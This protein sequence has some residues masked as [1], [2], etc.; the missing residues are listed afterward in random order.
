MKL[1]ES[2]KDY[3]RKFH[4]LSSDQRV[5]FLK[6]AY[7]EAL[8]KTDA[9]RGEFT[10]IALSP[11]TMTAP[12]SREEKEELLESASKLNFLM[13]RFYMERDPAYEGHIIELSLLRFE[14]LLL[15]GD[16][17]LSQDPQL[18]AE[19]FTARGKPELVRPAL[20]RLGEEVITTI[21]AD[22]LLNH[23]V[24]EQHVGDKT[25]VYKFR[26]RLH[27]LRTCEDYSKEQAARTLLSEG[28]DLRACDFNRWFATE[29]D[30]NIKIGNKHYVESRKEAAWLDLFIKKQTQ[31]DLTISIVSEQ[32]ALT[33]VEEEEKEDT[34]SSVKCSKESIIQLNEKI[35]RVIEGQGSNQ[36]TSWLRELA[37][38][39]SDHS[40]LRLDSANAVEASMWHFLWEGNFIKL[41]KQLKGDN[42][43]GETRNGLL[44]NKWALTHPE[45]Q[46]TLDPI[47]A[48]NSFA[49]ILAGDILVGDL[50]SAIQNFNDPLLQRYKNDAKISAAITLAWK[51]LHHPGQSDKK[52]NYK[53]PKNYLFSVA[54]SFHTYLTRAPHVVPYLTLLKASDV[55]ELGKQ[56]KNILR[57]I[58]DF[59]TIE[60][61][62]TQLGVANQIEA[63]FLKIFD[64]VYDR[65]TRHMSIT[66][67]AA[68]IITTIQDPIFKKYVEE[69]R[70]GERL[71]A[72]TRRTLTGKNRYA[73]DM[74]ALEGCKV[75]LTMYQSPVLRPYLE[76]KL[77]LSKLLHGMID[78][79]IAPDDPLLTAPYSLNGTSE[80]SLF[81]EESIEAYMI[82]DQLRAHID[83]QYMGRL[84]AYL[85]AI[86]SEM[87]TWTLS[88]PVMSRVDAQGKK[89]N[90]D[91]QTPD[92]FP[93]RSA[94]NFDPRVEF[95][96]NI[97]QR[98]QKLGG[99][100]R[101][102]ASIGVTNVIYRGIYVQPDRFAP[103]L[104]VV[105]RLL[106]S[107]MAELL[108]SDGLGND[109]LKEYRVLKQFLEIHRD[110]RV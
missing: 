97:Y 30:F 105:M 94:A 34:S 2:E 79:M 61:V 31:P 33:A 21:L 12:V 29:S 93:V 59:A 96:T 68:G 54:K 62:Y 46:R 15:R 53:P 42:P 45:H 57:S 47:L 104:D 103:A 102:S 72:A 5:P 91:Y 3:N 23:P 89:G 80:L 4:E 26:A 13:N 39:T 100:D 16:L 107:P 60:K 69:Q 37:A 17:A 106:D 86:N 28:F 101:D 77:Q 63:R 98:E 71:C 85:L 78:D 7:D 99:L 11:E 44:V 24:F 64:K 22:S 56:E 90:L 36:A 14:Y 81:P 51:A 110:S 25:I 1:Q 70:I 87:P 8:A 27:I 55:S 73:P 92:Y 48:Q 40:D 35:Q 82:A 88:N 76:G 10:P 66:N 38:L 32:T 74:S 6:Q 67:D 83:P 18:I 50:T 95:L 43:R 84:V 9:E 52:E 65:E 75:V 20:E 41:A 108:P 58:E 49:M 109:A 19:F